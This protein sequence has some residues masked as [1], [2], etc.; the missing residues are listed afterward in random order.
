MLEFEPLIP[1]SLWLALA[2]FAAV[3]LGWY[4]LRRPSIMRPSRWW[5][6]I[7]LMGLGLAMI[8]ALLLNPIWAR[9]LP[10]PAGKPVLTVLVDQSSSMAVGDADGAKSRYSVATRLA[11][12][13]QSGT[14]ELFDVRLRGF[15]RSTRALDGAALDADPSGASTDLGAAITTSIGGD[16]AAGEAIVLLSDGIHNTGNG[17]APVL[18][19]VRL[20]RAMDAP[21]FTRTFGGDAR[22]ADLAIELR[23]AQDLAIIAQRSPITA[24]VTNAGYNAAQ[25][26]VSL[27]RDGAEVGKKTIDLAGSSSAEVHFSVSHEAPGV[28]P[29]E[30]RVEPIAGETARSNNSAA[31]VL[32]VVAEPVRV[33][34]LEGKPYWDN[35]FFLRTLM[36]DQAVA[37]DSVVRLTD[38]RMLRRVLT[39]KPAEKKDDTS[40]AT[41]DD[42]WTIVSDPKELLADAARLR[43]YQIVVLGRDSE[44]FLGKE[45]I[46]NLQDWIADEG[47]S[48]VCYRGAPTSAENES[49]AK[50][51]PVKFSPGN[52]AGERFRLTLTES[53]EKAEWLRASD[54]A[55]IANLVSAMPS[56]TTSTV[57]DAAKPLAVTLANSVSKDNTQA[58][59]VVYQPYGSGRVVVIEGAGMWRWAFLPPKFG[60]QENVYPKLWHS[61]LRWLTSGAKLQPGQ[62]Y[63]LRTDKV[64]FGATEPATVTVLA[65]ENI[66]QA[67][68]PAVELMTEG[69][70]EKKSFVASASGEEAG[71]FRVSFGALPEGRYR[72]QLAGARDE[73]AS[74]H[75]V[76]EVRSF[77]REQLDLRARP[78][79]MARI[80]D[81][82]GGAA[83]GD[84]VV[85]EVKQ[86]F[87]DYRARTHPPQVIRTSAW[88]RWWVLAG[89]IGL[90]AVSWFVRRSGGLV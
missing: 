27:L 33:L 90:W 48:L 31:Y 5:T 4:A 8:F 65:R 79:L 20:A 15:D 68:L 51:M 16:V 14:S 1:L 49:L 43:T 69:A 38:T 78:D 34:V 21:I 55:S 12:Q 17:S 52:R 72:A 23:S 64:R 3:A 25:A 70:A 40:L 47:G 41:R 81:D 54:D 44:P 37:I 2:A 82:S 62:K 24:Q 66:G 29:Y 35:K 89:V 86:K 88:D 39:H 71:V 84:D 46:A 75:V 19:A 77:D 6:C 50:L 18:D 61:M 76:F 13:L 83:L 67:N 85:R 59:A 58:P 45:A 36:S 80:A 87:A 74:A 10:P 7:A 9:P 63:N 22:Q 11:K 30:V 26:V 32:R 73:D 53:G 28:F 57:I 56:L 42:A 60:Q